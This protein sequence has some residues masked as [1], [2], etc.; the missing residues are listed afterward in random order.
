[1]LSVE[2][3]RNMMVLT[4]VPMLAADASGTIVVVN[5]E[6][7]ELFGYREGDLVGQ[8]IECL[9]PERHRHHHADYVSAFMRVPAKRKMGNGRTITGLAKSRE[10][11]PTELA[12]STIEIQ[13]QLYS[14]VAAVDVRTR[15]DHQRMMELAMDAS[16]VAMM[17][18]NE[19]GQIVLT[20]TAAAE[21]TGYSREELMT[22]G[23]EALVDPEKRIA[24]TVFRAN[25]SSRAE[26]RQ[27]GEGGTLHLWRKDGKQLPVD[28][29]LT[30]VETPEGKMVMT[31]VTD[32]TD[33]TEMIAGETAIRAKNV[34]LG[35]VNRNLA[36]ANSELQHFAYAVSHD[37][38]APLSSILGL[39]QLVDEDILSGDL[40]G[41]SSTLKRAIAICERSRS[42]VERI[43]KFSQ[44]VE[45]D[46]PVPIDLA[47][48]VDG[49]WQET[50]PSQKVEARLNCDF[51]VDQVIANPESVEVILHNLLLNAVK[52]HDPNKPGA[53]VHVMSHKIEGGVEV[54]VSD[55]GVGID[56]AHHE[57]VFEMFRRAD[58]RSGDGIGL[59]LVRKQANLI[60][61]EVSLSSSLGEGTIV[62]L[63]LR[64]EEDAA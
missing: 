2:T 41:G 52:Y 25:F 5:E 34:E 20:N 32:L 62:K 56:P 58:S 1:M 46:G 39:L 11:I 8:P 15:L 10:E 38:K 12:L 61:G 6:F 23:V 7:E 29:V 36:E 9:V 19:K 59:A 4:S 54:I 22:I 55:N 51:E 45:H 14:M 17:M 28:V 50:T 64:N 48:L 16:A 35:E 53:V 42:K 3:L 33:L 26:R 37:L 63:T 49:V 31:T 13:G 47:T 57:R 60:G 40:D 18:I 24:H 27:M 30:P 21:L 43:L 44:T